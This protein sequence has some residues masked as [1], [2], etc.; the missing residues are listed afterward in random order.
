MAAPKKTTPGIRVVA[1]TAGFR[2][3]G[4]AW[5]VEPS[6]VPLRDLNKEQIAQIRAEPLLAVIDIDIDIASA[7]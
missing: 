3:A 7:E 4:R 5:S 2:R 6:D 1:T